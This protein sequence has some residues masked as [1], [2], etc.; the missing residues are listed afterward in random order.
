MSNMSRVRSTGMFLGFAALAVM[1][2]GEARAQAVANNP[3]GVIYNWGELPGDRKMGVVT[4]IQ[5]DPDGEH[6]WI[7]ERCGGNQCAGSNLSPIHKLDMEGKVVKSIGAG[8][9][10]WPHG[11]DLDEE[12]NLMGDGGGAGRGPSGRAGLQD[13][14]GPPGLQT[15]PARRGTDDVGRGWGA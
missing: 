14:D 13:G 12:G 4:G 1:V 7:L 9:F 5:P 2:A 15:E 3:Y 6:L 10:A 8:L 11:F